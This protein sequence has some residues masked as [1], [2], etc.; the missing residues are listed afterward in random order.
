VLALPA[1]ETSPGWGG[2]L[3][4]AIVNSLLWRRSGDPDETLDSYERLVD[5]AADSGWL[6]DPETLKVAAK[7]DPAP[8]EL[9]LSRTLELREHLFDLFTAV[10]AHEPLPAVPLS[11][12]SEVFTQAL[13]QLQLTA[14]EPGARVDWRSPFDADLP[15]FLVTISA[16]DMVTSDYRDR[17]KQCPGERCGW[18]FYDTTRNRSRR[19]CE[20][21]QCGNRAR[22]K[23][24]YERH[25]VS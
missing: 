12:L 11:R 10:A 25:R 14:G 19:W 23:R 24:Y 15:L 1:D 22:A 17:I 9:V 2:R 5:V 4:F 6:P 3:S 20:D 16:A 21:S 18:V 7:R 13:S 8:A